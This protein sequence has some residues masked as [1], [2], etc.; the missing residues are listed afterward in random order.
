[1]VDITQLCHHVEDCSAPINRIEAY[2]CHRLLI[3]QEFIDGKDAFGKAHRS[4]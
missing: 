2:R 4:L 1:M 3:Q